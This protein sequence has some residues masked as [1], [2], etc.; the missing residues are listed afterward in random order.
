MLASSRASFDSDRNVSIFFTV[1][2]YSSKYL[3][4]LIF[5]EVIHSKLLWRDVAEFDVIVRPHRLIQCA[6]TLVIIHY[7]AWQSAS[8]LEVDG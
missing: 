8:R 3:R 1:T 4:R 2:L 6:L 5:I 7:R